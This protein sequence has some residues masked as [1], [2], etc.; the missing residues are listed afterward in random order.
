MFSWFMNYLSGNYAADYMEEYIEDFLAHEFRSR[1]MLE[2]K[3]KYLDD[4]I[5]KQASS[6]DCGS[7]WSVHYGCENNIMKRLKLMKELELPEDEIREYLRKHWNFSAVRK[8]EIKEKLECGELEEAIQIL[9]ESKLLD[10]AYPGLVAHYSEQ[11]ISIY[12][13]QSDN[14]ACKEE[15]MYYVFECPQTELVYIYKL[16]E[17]CTDAEWNEYREQI[18]QNPKNHSIF[19]P[20]MESEKMYE[21]MLECL[22]KEEFIFN[23]DRYEKI[24]K[25][26]F[27]EQVRDIYVAYLY[28]EAKR[29][30]DRKRYR[31]LMRYLKKLRKYPDGKEKAAEIAENWRSVYYRRSAMMDEMRKAGFN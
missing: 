28:R 25:E 2:K 29:A 20:F 10:R 8:L 11:L 17:L 27:P 13:M 1:E 24:M 31:E 18:L 5:E 22:K 3:L 30:N 12:E 4:M 15:L 19:Y 7:I 9:C 26:K 6:T 21:R 23:M 16:K 14:K